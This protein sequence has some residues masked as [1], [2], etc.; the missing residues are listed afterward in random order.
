M[1]HTTNPV[2]YAVGLMTHQ[3]LLPLPQKVV[4]KFGDV[5]V[6]KGNIVGNGAYKLKNH[7]INEKIKFT[8]LNKVLESGKIYLG[9]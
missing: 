4:E 2:P 3:S 5:W 8:N 6:K 7:I 9:K 1:V